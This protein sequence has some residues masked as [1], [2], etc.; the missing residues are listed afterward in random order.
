VKPTIMPH[1][2]IH[3]TKH[4]EYLHRI[5]NKAVKFQRDVL[6]PFRVN[7]GLCEWRHYAVDNN[8]SVIQEA[9]GNLA[10]H[11]YEWKRVQD[12]PE[13]MRG[14]KATLFRN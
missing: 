1:K 9:Q 8:A 13:E 2:T 3:D 14:E 10:N 6:H 12:S 4:K 11:S 5:E 7:N